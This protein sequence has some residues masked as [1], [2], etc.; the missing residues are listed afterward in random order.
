VEDVVDPRDMGTVT[1]TRAAVQNTLTAAVMACHRR[2]R[3]T[4][5]TTYK[6]ARTRLRNKPN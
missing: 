2:L 3:L 4:D 5:V 6:T 1:P